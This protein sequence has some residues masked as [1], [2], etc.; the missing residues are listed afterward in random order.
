MKHINFNGFEEGKT[1]KA[2]QIAKKMKDKNMPIDEIVELTGLT[3]KE[4]EQL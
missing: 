2:K 4:I 3:K 1:E